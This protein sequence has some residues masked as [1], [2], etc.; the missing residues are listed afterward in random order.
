DHLGDVK[1]V[2]RR[3]RDVRARAYVIIVGHAD[4]LPCIVLDDHL[5]S[6]IDC[7]ANRFRRHTDTVLQ[8]LY[9]FWYADA[10][11]TPSC[12]KRSTQSAPYCERSLSFRFYRICCAGSDPRA[13][14]G[15]HD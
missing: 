13:L 9:L 10:H 4:A 2:S 12:P 15:D 7:L 8:Y 1:H 6:V 3:C 5:M 14:T 11:E